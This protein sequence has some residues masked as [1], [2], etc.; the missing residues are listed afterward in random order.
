MNI[1]LDT[2]FTDFVD[3]DLIS[4]GLVDENGR[5]FYA[6]LTDYRQEA[7]SD[8]VKQVVLPLLGRHKNT[9]KGNQF[10]VAKELNEWLKHYDDG[11][12]LANICFDYNTDW[13]LFVRML[14]LLPKEELVTNITATNIWGSLNKIKLDYFWL[15]RSDLGWTPHM[16]LWDAHGNRFSYQPPLTPEQI[17]MLKNNV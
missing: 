10:S 16:A 9:V 8:F 17:E 5:E 12:N 4:I 3:C 2:E 13:D 1:F 11:T 7:C 6:E 15:E 14:T